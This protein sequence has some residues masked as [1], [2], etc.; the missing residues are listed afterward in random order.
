MI[1]LINKMYIKSLALEWIFGRKQSEWRL[2]VYSEKHVGLCAAHLYGKPA[3]K[4]NE[5]L[6]LV[7]RK[8]TFLLQGDHPTAVLM[9]HINLLR[10]KVYMKGTVVMDLFLR[11]YKLP[12]CTTKIR[13]PNPSQR[14]INA[15]PGSFKMFYLN[16]NSYIK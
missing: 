8:Y 10:Q 5:C 11:N 4:N 15:I 1:S 14:R 12:L 9:S 3:P 2:P 16:I 7:T 13:P 6:P